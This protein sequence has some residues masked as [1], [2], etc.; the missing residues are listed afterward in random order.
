VQV[1]WNGN[2]Y[3]VQIDTA[4]PG[5]I[6]K[7]QLFSLTGVAPD[8]QKI[9]VK[10]GILKDDADMSSFGFKQDQILMMMG[11]VGELPKEPPKPT[12]FV[13]DMSDNQIAEA[14]KL[15][16]GLV[17]LGN[18]CYMNATIQCL[19]AVPDMKLALE[20]VNST[21]SRDSY[22]NLALSLRALLQSM[23][24]SGAAVHPMVFLQVLRS[25]FPQFGEQ[26][27]RGFMQQDAEECWGQLI[28]A[29]DQKLPGLKADGTPEHQ[30]H[31]IEQFMTLE[32]LQETKCDDAPQEPPK[33][34]LE[35]LN[36]LR[37][38]IGAGV[39]TYLVTE[40]Q[41]SLIEKLEKNSATLGRNAIYTKTSKIS[42]LPKYLTVNFVRFQWKPQEK[43]KAKILKRV[44]FPFELDM[45]TF[46]TPEL[47]QKLQKG[48]AHIKT[49][50]EKKAEN[51]KLK[52]EDDQMQVDETK[53]QLQIL[54]D[55]GADQI[56]LDDPGLNPSGLYDLVAVLTHMGRAADSGH[57]IGWS[58]DEN[59]KWWKYDDDKV[60]PCKEEDITK[61]EGGGDWHSAYICLYRSKA[62]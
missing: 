41:N 23:E 32:L 40:I 51:R 44:Q 55:I 25:V 61:L 27:N 2:K 33:T 62:L 35:T 36:K 31:F 9:M 47:Q 7:T 46:C 57:Y 42:R 10:G 15:P 21:A 39:S 60:S 30:K 52:L 17:N 28:S 45:V 6:F 29:L 5:I 49:V 18:T 48:K 11:T 43:I 56:F 38:N 16:T 59:N 58:K 13:E 1:K 8:R 54:K 26:D 37:V 14:L 24:G 12:Q 34:T 22:L 50:E 19:R 53:D 20:K 4:Q 3:P